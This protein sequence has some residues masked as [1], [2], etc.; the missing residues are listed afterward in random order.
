MRVLVAGAGPGFEGDSVDHSAPIVFAID[1]VLT[2]D[3]CASLVARIDA[4]G[5]ELAPITT[6]AGERMMENVRNNERV[7]FDDHALA[8]DLFRRVAASLPPIFGMRP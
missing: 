6:S 4:A 3:E 8:A 1:D 2:A 5:P 7:M